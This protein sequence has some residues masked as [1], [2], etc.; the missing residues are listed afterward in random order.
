MSSGSGAGGKSGDRSVAVN[1]LLI[2][3]NA[4]LA[5]E[6]AVAHARQAAGGVSG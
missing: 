6:V 1:R 2:A 4:G 3:D 5:A